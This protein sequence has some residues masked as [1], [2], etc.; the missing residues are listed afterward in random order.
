MSQEELPEQIHVLEDEYDQDLAV[1]LKSE[2][3]RKQWAV[4][5]MKHGIQ[6]FS[7]LLALEKH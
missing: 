5:Q 1:H 4:D 2:V 3:D 6:I 7:T